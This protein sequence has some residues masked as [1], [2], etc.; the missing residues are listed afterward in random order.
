MRF[1]ILIGDPLFFGAAALLVH[2]TR[3]LLRGH[4][5]GLG[6]GHGLVCFMR[7]AET[8][9]DCQAARF[10]P[11]DGILQ[12]Q[13]RLQQ[14]LEGETHTKLP[15]THASRRPHDTQFP[16]QRAYAT[17]V[18]ES[19]VEKRFCRFSFVRWGDSSSG[20]VGKGL[21]DIAETRVG[22]FFFVIGRHGSAAHPRPHWC[23]VSLN[24]DIAT[25]IS[26]QLMTTTPP[27]PTRYVRPIGG[28][29]RPG[30]RPP[31]C[32]TTSPCSLGWSTCGW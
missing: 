20:H 8:H 2:H 11:T 6:F 21:D 28:G 9:R 17:R 14:I 26:L 7:S 32:S 1:S 22:F 5:V 30:Q 29:E 3:N 13:P 24:F 23:V 27:S 19:S 25:H 4:R 31:P 16:R 18:H 15:P 10:S 12:T